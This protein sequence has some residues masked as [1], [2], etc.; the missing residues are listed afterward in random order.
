MWLPNITHTGIC[1]QRSTWS[2]LTLL[3]SN[4]LL[5]YSFL[6]PSEINERN[7]LEQIVQ[8]S[9]MADCLRLSKI[10]MFLIVI[11]QCQLIFFACMYYYLILVN[12]NPACYH[13]CSHNLLS[14]SFRSVCN[15]LWLHGV[16]SNRC[17]VYQTRSRS[18]PVYQT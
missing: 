12:H 4:F 2:K 6:P 10:D 13:S 18:H 9:L 15:H 1:N 16:W 8:F 3:K 5:I 7:E 14:Y 17:L 11:A